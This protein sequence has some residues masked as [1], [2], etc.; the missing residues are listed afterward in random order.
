LDEAA[1][2]RR[3]NLFAMRSM[4][5]FSSSAERATGFGLK[6][7]VCD[8]MVPPNAFADAASDLSDSI[9]P[10]WLSA[11]VCIKTKVRFQSIDWKTVLLF[12]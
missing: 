11:A 8:D 3:A 6:P 5:A 4:P 10:N 12:I 2:A 1:E 9:S 7:P